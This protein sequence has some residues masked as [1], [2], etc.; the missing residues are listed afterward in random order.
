MMLSYVLLAAQATLS[1][2]RHAWQVSSEGLEGRPG[3]QSE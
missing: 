2:T 3:I 1:R